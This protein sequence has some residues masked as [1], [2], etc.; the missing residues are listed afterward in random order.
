MQGNTLKQRENS[1]K[2][3]L[4]MRGRTD[5]FEIKKNEITYLTTNS[6]FCTTRIIQNKCVEN[7][8]CTVKK[9]R[10]FYFNKQKFYHDLMERI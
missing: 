10:F 1:A 3:S 6:I 5:C 4:K 2:V 8:T 7:N 9:I